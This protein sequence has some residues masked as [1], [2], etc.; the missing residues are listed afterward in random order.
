[1]TGGAHKPTAGRDYVGVGVGALV[2]DGAGRVLL[3]RR[4]EGA[5]NERGFWE[6]P[7]G[8]VEFGETLRDATRREFR[9]EYGVE[10]DVLELLGAFD[11]I[12]SGEGEHWVSLTFL[13]RHV[14]GVPVVAEPA[15]CSEVGWFALDA[16]PRPL[17]QISELNYAA[18][19]EKYGL[20]KFW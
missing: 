19:A 4:A 2:F 7:G 12:L 15:K 10:I 8:R 20:G 9:E 3:A 17:S 5:T 14:S 18:Y 11:H 16:L 1:M 6:F 13:A